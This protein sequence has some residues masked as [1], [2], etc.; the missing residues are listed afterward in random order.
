MRAVFPNLSLSRNG[1]T[2]VKSS[3]EKAAP[4]GCVEL[5]PG[6]AAHRQQ[7]VVLIDAPRQM[8][9]RG[10]TVAPGAPARRQPVPEPAEAVFARC[11]WQSAGSRHA[12]RGPHTPPIRRRCAL[13]ALGGGE[14]RRGA[15]RQSRRAFP[16]QSPLRQNPP[17]R[18]RTACWPRCCA[19]RRP[20]LD[21]RSRGD[22]RRGAELRR[23]PAS[24]LSRR[25]W[26]L[27]RRAADAGRS[28]ARP[29][30]RLRRHLP[31][32]ARRAVA[33]GRALA[34]RRRRARALDDAERKRAIGIPVE[35]ACYNA[36]V[37]LINLDA[38]P[39][40]RVGE[41]LLDY[42]AR[43]PISVLARGSGRP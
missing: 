32:A 23:R 21:L 18:L 1:C 9:A 6:V 34:A 2:A 24:S 36:G 37:I 22:P 30:S 42:A 20:A 7:L 40:E 10:P 25:L 28:R 27:F 12:R 41:R 43:W 33:P 14:H 29:L 19:R 4:E 35:G 3:A 15:V 31:R 8:R 17:A 26:P 16:S 11:V 39:R 5:A 38:W 13:R